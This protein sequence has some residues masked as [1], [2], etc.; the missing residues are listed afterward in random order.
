METEILKIKEKKLKVLEERRKQLFE[1][2]KPIND[3]LESNYNKIEELKKE[4][5]KLLLAD[6]P[7]NWEV[8][9]NSDFSVYHQFDEA[10]VKKGLI[11]GGEIPEISQ[12]CIEMKLS[13]DDK[14]SL[15]KTIMSINEILPFIKPMNT[16][17]YEGFKYIGIFDHTLSQYASYFALINSE[18]KVF[19][20]M[21]QRYSIR[22]EIKTFDSLESLVKYVQENYWFDKKEEK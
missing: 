12:R 2:Q 21:Q 18:K 7:F 9:L 16:R 5:G 4:I 13:K 15:R 11:Y 6:N 22:K 8:L 19:K 17:D 10:L 20:I 1:L 14:K 3:E